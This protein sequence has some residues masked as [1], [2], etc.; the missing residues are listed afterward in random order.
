MG[1]RSVERRLRQVAVRLTSL[2][3]ELQ[4]LDEQHLHL[5]GDADDARLQALMSETPLSDRARRDA[6]RHAEAVG[7]RRVDVLSQ[8]EE[9]ERRQDELLDELT[10]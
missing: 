10:G 2:R 9:L 5:A 3:N 7:K 6:A 8:I 4:I 1:T